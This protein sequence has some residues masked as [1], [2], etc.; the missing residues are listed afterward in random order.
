MLSL[1][2]RSFV[3]CECMPCIINV[4]LYHLLIVVMSYKIERNNLIVLEGTPS[5]TLLPAEQFK[6]SF[7]SK[8][9]LCIDVQGGSFFL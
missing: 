9:C 8:S 1:V 3:L 4:T 7:I 6:F 5:S 2:L